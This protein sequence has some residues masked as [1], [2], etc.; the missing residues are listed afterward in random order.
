MDQ[1]NQVKKNPV[2]SASGFTLVELMIVVA[3]IG[4]LAAVAIPNYQK[5]Q[6]RARQSEAK[7]SLASVYTTETSYAAENSSF[8]ECITDIGYASTG[9]NLY[10]AVGWGAAPGGG[11]TCGPLG[12]TGCNQTF[13][14]AVAAACVSIPATY[15]NATISASAPTTALATQAQIPAGTLMT[16]TTFTAGAGGWVSTSNTTT[17][18]QWTIDQTKTLYNVSSNL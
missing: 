13:N 8:S 11:N 12:N 15:V 5:Y 3:I 10:Y 1:I 18:D 14:T 2:G 4:I 6:A 16:K 9:K 7:I 17:A